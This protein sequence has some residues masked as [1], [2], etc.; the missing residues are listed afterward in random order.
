MLC[1]TFPAGS[2]PRLWEIRHLMEEMKAS[3]DP[4]VMYGT[5]YFLTHLM[6]DSIARSLIHF[7]HRNSSLFISNLQ[8]PTT[9]LTIGSHRLHHLFYFPSTPSNISISI[10]VLSYESKLDVSL[11][12]SSILIP[13]AKKLSKLL[14]KHINLLTSLLS[15]R[16]V[17]AESRSKK[18]PHHV[19]IE[20]PVGS[21]KT[22]LPVLIPDVVSPADI[23]IPSSVSTTSG[24]TNSR[25][26]TPASVMKA[27]I[28]ELM[29]RLHQVQQELNLLNESLEH[30]ESEDETMIR[31]IHSRIEDLK[32]EFSDLMKQLRRRKSVADYG[33]SCHHPNIVVD[34]EVIVLFLSELSS[35]DATL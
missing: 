29:D 20:A 27:T 11:M 6:P 13:S 3:A 4:A 35:I 33:I 18:R 1:L 19:I 31:S 25:V 30:Y 28:P 15:N 8:G 7:V 17:S 24:L 12:T 10:N 5:H 32:D 21:G 9:S 22:P 26:S 34:V 16:R 23:H 2:I 14:H